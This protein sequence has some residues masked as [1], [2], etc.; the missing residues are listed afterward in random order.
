MI[1]AIQA[2]EP[3]TQRQL[4]S[5]HFRDIQP[6]DWR[7]LQRFHERLSP[8]TVELRFHGA[9]RQLSM[10]LAYR[11]THVDGINEAAVVATTGTRGRIVGVARYSKIDERSAEVAFVVEDRYQR[12][13]V[14]HRLLQRLCREAR[15]H[16]IEEFVAEILPNNVPM[17]RLLAEIGS[18]SSHYSGGCCT[19]RVRL[20]PDC[21]NSR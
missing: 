10:P 13:H 4:R 9:K 11:F 16:G 2:P 15:E 1:P 18:F 12:H 20:N 8:Q 21:V 5:L 14:G 7:R 17:F 3:I 19:A 6:G